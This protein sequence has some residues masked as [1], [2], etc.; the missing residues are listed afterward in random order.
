MCRVEPGDGDGDSDGD[1][2]DDAV[3]VTSAYIPPDSAAFE[4]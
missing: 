3:T 1:S 2:D 4:L